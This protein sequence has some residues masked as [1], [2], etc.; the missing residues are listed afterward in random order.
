MNSKELAGLRRDFSSRT[1]DEASAAQDPFE[2]FDLWLGEA[3]ASSI[4]DANA[5]ALSTVNAD[6]RPSSRIVLLKGYGREGFDFFTNY[7]SRKASDLA[8]NPN[9]VLHFFW[10]ELERQVII[11][12]QAAKVSREES[13]AYFASRPRASR[14]GAWASEQSSRIAGREVLEQRVDEMNE[15]FPGDDIPLPPFWGGY[16]VKPERFEFWQGRSSR[17]HDRICFERNGDGWNIFRLS[18]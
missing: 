16:R 6:C 10:A 1:F 17:L 8:A 4:V 15:R 14:I 9:V 7:G 13:E 18:P 12:G 3:L 11:S 2:Q 5:M